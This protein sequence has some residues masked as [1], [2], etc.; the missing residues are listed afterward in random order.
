MF[1]EC[2]DFAKRTRYGV[3]YVNITKTSLLHS[4]GITH[5]SGIRCTLTNVRCS[6]CK[7]MISSFPCLS[8]YVDAAG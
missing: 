1:A 4:V 7:I 5:Q 6:P 8:T 2:D 3:E